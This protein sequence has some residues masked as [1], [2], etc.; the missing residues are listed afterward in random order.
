[1]SLPCG[2]D[3]AGMPFGLQLVGA[4]RGDRRLLDIAQSLEAAWLHDETLRRPRP[5]LAK[6]SQPVPALKSIVTDPPLLR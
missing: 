4:F 5:D 2:L 3:H 6:L 1:M